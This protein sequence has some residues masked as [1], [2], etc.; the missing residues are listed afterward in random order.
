MPIAPIITF[1]AGQCEVDV[2]C[3]HL[4]LRTLLSVDALTCF[5]RTD[6]RGLSRS[7]LSL[8]QALSTYILKMVSLVCIH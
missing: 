6:R 8:S 7:S 5:D 1:K 3:S 2:C 4:G